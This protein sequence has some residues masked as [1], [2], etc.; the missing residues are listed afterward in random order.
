MQCQKCGINIEQEDFTDL[1]RIE[2]H[3][4]HPSFMDN[5]KGLGRTI[6]LCR[7]CHIVRL[8]PMIFDIIRK[9]S[10][11]FCNKN[12]SWHWVWNYHVAPINRQECIN[13][14]I[15]FTERWLGEANN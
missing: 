5:P 10:N 3:H 13:E 15:N 4:L 7:H 14:V 6:P 12:K 1:H 11:L 9:H 8:H 2:Y